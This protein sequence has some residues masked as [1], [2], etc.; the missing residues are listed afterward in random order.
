M[1]P[2][3]PN[4][5][6]A[7]AG[8]LFELQPFSGLRLLDIRLPTA[9][10]D[11]Y[12]GPRFG[13]EGTRRLAGVATGPLIGTI[14]KPS[15]GFDAQQTADLVKTLVEAG[16]AR[17]RD[18]GWMD[19]HLPP[20]FAALA[21]TGA[22]IAHYKVGQDDALAAAD[23]VLMAVPDRLIGKI[24]HSFIAKVR[25]GTAIIMLNAAAP[26]AGDLPTRDDVTYFVTHPCHPP[27]RSA[28]E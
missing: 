6:A 19:R 1:G 18:P 14:I 2:S 16:I 7:V 20:M 13:V 22:P 11:R 10:A 25:P 17:S 24:A 3:L 4:L 15:V 9:F 27:A 12:P 5:M 26:Y 21:A 8:N 28:A 23:V